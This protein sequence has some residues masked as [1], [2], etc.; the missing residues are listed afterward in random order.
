MKKI[1]SLYKLTASDGQRK[2]ESSEG[3]FESF[4][5][6]RKWFKFVVVE[7]KVLL[8]SLCVHLYSGFVYI[9][10]EESRNHC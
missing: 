6:S 9:A 1:G 10:T 3:S 7:S 5:I 8:L 4:S 2:K